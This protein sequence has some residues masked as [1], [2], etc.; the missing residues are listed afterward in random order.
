[1]SFSLRCL[2]ICFLLQNP[3]KPHLMQILLNVTLLLPRV[4][5]L[6]LT[7]VAIIGME[8]QDTMTILIQAIG[9]QIFHGDNRTQS[10]DNCSCY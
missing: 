2:F 9:G 5:V 10:H 1:M 3:V 8:V 4:L 6:I 7:A